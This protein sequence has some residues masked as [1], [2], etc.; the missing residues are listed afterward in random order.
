MTRLAWVGH[1][2]REYKTAPSAFSVTMLVALTTSRRRGLASMC[3]KVTLITGGNRG[4][5]L[6]IARAFVASGA[7]V[8]IAGRDLSRCEAAVRSLASS[9]GTAMAV[10]LDVT[11]PPSVEAAIRTVVE[12]F[13]GLDI[14]IN[15]AALVGPL[16]VIADA[17]A[18]LWRETIETNLI[19]AANTAIAC[20]PHLI[21]SRG[22]VI[23]ITAGAA[24]NPVSGMSA[25][26]CSKAGLAMLTKCLAENT[27]AR[28]YVVSAS[29]PAFSIPRCSPRCR[30]DLC[31]NWLSGAFLAG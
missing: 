29:G 12:R 3:N 1:S 13:D 31:G 14:L 10:C 23:N 25:Y 22:T 4:F 16:S 7:K 2:G 9:P 18:P 5:G 8:A 6:A 27:A 11:D 28:A 17:P 30:R 21:R 15:N 26:C 19:G 20:L 24:D